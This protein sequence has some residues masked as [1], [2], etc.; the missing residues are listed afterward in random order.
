MSI[1]H[2]SKTFRNLENSNENSHE[3]ITELETQIH[4]IIQMINALRVPVSQ[5]G[6]ETNFTGTG[7]LS[8]RKL[9]PVIRQAIITVIN[10]F[11][12]SATEWK[13]MIVT[14]KKICSKS[15]YY[16]TIEYLNSRSLLQGKQRQGTGTKK[17]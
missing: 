12:D 13:D 7:K 17:G 6:T 9:S 4:E 5:I 1:L 16:R 2:I 15:T 8:R 3:R 10:E 11:P 14:K